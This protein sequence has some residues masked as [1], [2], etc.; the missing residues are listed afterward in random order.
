MKH[1]SSIFMHE[2]IHYIVLDFSYFTFYHFLKRNLILAIIM[3]P[4]LPFCVKCFLTSMLLHHRSFCLE[5]HPSLLWINLTLWDSAQ[6]SPPLRRL[7]WVPQAGVMVLLLLAQ[8]LPLNPL[9]T[10]P[11]HFIIVI[12]LTCLCHS[13]EG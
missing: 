3:N 2:V 11:H 10:L 7:S 8:H 9:T 5:S 12:L 13:F 4:V 1:I 6:A